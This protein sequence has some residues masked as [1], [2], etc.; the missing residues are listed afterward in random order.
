MQHDMMAITG[1]YDHRLVLLSVLISI[2]ACYAALDLT[3]RTAAA[4]GRVRW[5]WLMG[6]AT[7]MGLGIWSMHYIG[8]LAFHLPV[9]IKYDV[10]L[11]LI[12]L[13]VA[14][15]ASG[16]ALYSVSVN[17]LTKL[18][19]LAGAIIMGVGIG[20]M[21]YIGMAAMLMPAVCHYHPSAVALSL[22][23]PALVSLGAL[24]PVFKFGR[25]SKGP[26]W[27][28]VAIAVILGLASV[29]MHYTGMTA[30]SYT[31]SPVAPDDSSAIS[32]SSLGVAGIVVVTLIVLFFGILT[33]LADQRFSAQALELKASEERY[34]LLFERTPAGVFRTS[35]DGSLLEANEACSRIFGYA[36]RQEQMANKVQ[37]HYFDPAERSTFIEKVQREGI[38]TNEER[39]FR[40]ADGSTVWVL[41]NA[42]LVDGND[43][44][45][46]VMEGTLID[47]TDRKMM[48]A[49][50]ERARG[51]AET[52]SRAK[53]DFLATMSHEIRT[54]MN[55]IIGMTDLVLETELTADQR[56]SLQMVKASGEAL[57]AIINDILDF[58]K[59]EA[60]K[61]EL[62]SVPFNLNESLAATLKAASLRAHQKGLELVYEVDPEI[63]DVLMGD[64]GR[65]RQIL[66]NLVGNAIKFTEAGEVV[67]SV[68]Q[69]STGPNGLHLHFKV[70]DTGIGIAREAQ[71]KIFQPFS[72]AD[73]STTRRFGGTGLGLSISTRLVEKMNGRIWVESQMDHGSVFHFTVQLGVQSNRATQSQLTGS[74]QI[75]DAI[76]LI[77]DDNST[78]RSVLENILTRWGIKATAVESGDNAIRALEAA[79]S[80]GHP[81][82]LLLLDRHMPEM[83]GFE[84][85][86]QIKRIT[87]MS[88]GII[89]ML[90]SESYPA[91]AARC[92]ALGI[93]AHL[94]KP[95]GQ[96]ELLE[97]IRQ[98]LHVGPKITG[99]RMLNQQMP[100][101]D[102]RGLRVLLAEDNLVN[103][104]LATRLLEKRGFSVV[105]VGDGRAAIDATA[106]NYFDIV[107]MD[108]QMPGM[109]GLQAV[110]EI[111]RREQKTG[112]HLPVI[113]LTAHALAGDQERCLAAG[114]DDYVSKPIDKAELFAAIGRVVPSMSLPVGTGET[115]D[116]P[117]VPIV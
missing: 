22:V 12:S 8:M 106:T 94:L 89:M 55:G 74:E 28:R 6:G 58:S 29:A 10:P 15:A 71:K 39:R 20:A 35:L 4:R 38:V 92:R 30:V 86:E 82:Q 59:I 68:D 13:L 108:V 36:S 5:A 41:E 66:T 99:E 27:L 67:V 85:A 91:D 95:I 14:V 81:F 97:S 54:P 17:G 69:E 63:P 110:A 73:G 77:V 25:S 43:G 83:D 87:G 107:L 11:V 62:D 42:I 44:K 21:H 79:A 34:R 116:L 16:I 32:I 23:I 52:A 93:P 33:S 26:S 1:W 112:G 37:N 50:L 2:C 18:K 96:I 9:P 65:L 48:E 98:I 19:V 109:D 78:N 111:R 72:Q 70:Q 31:S 64:A 100:Q 56:G 3:G 117:A 61:M 57:L 75:F 80:E 90:T 51:T 104:K 53:S 84:V 101:T 102:W 47:I 105:V 113:A 24:W 60:G 40:R 115:A 7:T 88:D 114:M 49:E 76:A 103:Q 46:T 45:Q